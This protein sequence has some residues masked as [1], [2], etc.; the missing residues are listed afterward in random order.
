MLSLPNVP[1]MST[2]PISGTFFQLFLMLCLAVLGS[3]T[4]WADEGRV[5][6]VI[7]NGAYQ[8]VQAL[9][10]PPRDA[11]NVAD[12]LQQLGF[13]VTHLIDS[14]RPQM[15]K[16]LSDFAAAAA[17][18]DTAIVFYAGHGIEAGGQNLLIPVDAEIA[19]DTDASK[20]DIAPHQPRWRRPSRPAT[21]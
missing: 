17:K 9:P 3:K 20:R 10:N 6:L 2:R 18:A 12:A 8:K 16:A 13:N 15:N 11:S 19:S 1:L 4:G 21:C 14:D 7:G 5:A